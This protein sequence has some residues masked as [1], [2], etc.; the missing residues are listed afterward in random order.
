MQFDRNSSVKTEVDSQLFKKT[1]LEFRLLKY[2][3]DSRDIDFGQPE[4]CPLLELINTYVKGQ[5]T[6]H[7]MRR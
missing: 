6:R 7:R 3:T 1:D 5:R 2:Q 4:H